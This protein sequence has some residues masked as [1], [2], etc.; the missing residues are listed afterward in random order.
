[1]RGMPVKSAAPRKKTAPRKT[2]P[3]KITR[4]NLTGVAN[5]LPQT[6]IAGLGTTDEGFSFIVFA[7]GKG[8]KRE[9]WWHCG[10]CWQDSSESKAFSLEETDYE[11]SE[12]KPLCPAV[13]YRAQ[14]TI[15]WADGHPPTK[16]RV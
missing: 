11:L 4:R 2:P 10:G 16:V 3:K 9:F 6:E 1:M 8:K 14:I 5:E 15:V 7:Q 13:P 12:H